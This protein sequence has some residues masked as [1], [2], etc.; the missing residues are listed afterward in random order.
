MTTSGVTSFNVSRDDIIFMALED[1]KV[2][3]PDFESLPPAAVTRANKRLNMM[4][5]AMQAAGVG[6][7]LNLI[8]TLPLKAGAQY[9]SLGPSGDNCSAAMGETAIATAAI[10][11]STTIVV[12]D[13]SAI[14]TGQYIGI[15]LDDG[16]MQ[17]TTVNGAPVGS[18]VVLAAALTDSAAVGNVVFSYTS[19]ISRP[20]GI[21]EAR[22]QDVSGND[23][24]MT[25]VSWDEYTNLPLKSSSGKVIQYCFKPDT[26]NS[27]MYVWPVGDVISD[28]IVMT[29]RTPVQDFVNTDDTPDFPVEWADALHYMLA[30]RLV[31]AYDV[32]DKVANRVEK[33]AA[34]ALQDAN[35]FDREQNVSVF[36]VPSEY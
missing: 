36:F 10:A 33:L 15:Q 28:R 12:D 2:Y 35:N 20:I 25:S 6:L 32:S 11:G 5:K 4:I 7:W 27:K 17:W 16:T 23:L 24:S 34:I 3:A 21:V 29:V 9:Y 13:A 18:A 8:V 14:V 30:M 19:K 26:I 31:P 22:A 1:I